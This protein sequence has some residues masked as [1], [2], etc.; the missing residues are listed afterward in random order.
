MSR[1]QTKINPFNLE[2]RIAFLDKAGNLLYCVN[3]REAKYFLRSSQA[4]LL[5]QYPSTIQL[6]IEESEIIQPPKTNSCGGKNK[7]GNQNWLHFSK[8]EIYGNYRVQNPDG[9]EMF[10]CDAIKVLWYLNRSLIDIVGTDPP[11]VRLKFRPNGEG[12]H[13]DKYYLAPKVNRCVVCGR[14]NKLNRHHVVP[15][16]FRRHMPRVIKDH[17]YHDVLLLCLNCH[18]KY[19]R[20]ANELKAQLAQKHEIK[21]NPMI[22]YDENMGKAIKIAFALIRHGDRIP[23]ERRDFLLAQVAN[24]LNKTEV[25]E[26]DLL[27]F[28]GLNAYKKEEECEYG[29]IV[30]TFWNLQEFVE[31]WRKHFIEC[32]Q[33][34]YMPEFWDMKRGLL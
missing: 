18:E 14:D 26:E 21:M 11:I 30:L 2:K 4:K 23:K 29:Q 25:T 10:H 9:L 32:M 13:N 33:P 6:L 20:H 24:Y 28:S 8:S 5:L 16:C 12:H 17:S 22:Y 27:L 7:L 3:Q 31:M 1:G 19:E 15:H 34:K